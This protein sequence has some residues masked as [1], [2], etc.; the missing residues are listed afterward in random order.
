MDREVEAVAPRLMRMFAECVSWVWTAT[1]GSLNFGSITRPPISSLTPPRDE[2][3]PY[4][5]SPDLELQ[6][7]AMHKDALLRYTE[8]TALSSIPLGFS[9]FLGPFIKSE[10]RNSLLSSAAPLATEE[11]PSTDYP[12]SPEL[13]PQKQPGSR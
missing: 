12:K 3:R 5:S 9:V 1:M 11:T 13:K 8:G 7:S 4:G 6:I 2:D 10:I